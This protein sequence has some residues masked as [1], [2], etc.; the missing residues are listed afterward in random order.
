MKRMQTLVC[1]C[2]HKE[3]EIPWARWSNEVLVIYALGMNF[4]ICKECQEKNESFKLNAT[5]WAQAAL[6]N[7]ANIGVKASQSL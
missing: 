3:K 6:K 1:D 5:R 7:E 4:R 2:C